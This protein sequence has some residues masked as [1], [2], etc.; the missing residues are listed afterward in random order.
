MSSF[1]EKLKMFNNKA[2]NENQKQQKPKFQS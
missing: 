2:A 1:A